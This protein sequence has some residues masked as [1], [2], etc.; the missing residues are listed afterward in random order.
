MINA[1]ANAA[2]LEA[3]LW[4]Q[5]LSGHPQYAGEVHQF[6]VRHAA[7][8]EFNSRNDV[9]AHI[10]TYQ[11]AFRRELS[12]RQTEP[13]AQAHQL[14]AYGVLGFGHSASNQRRQTLLLLAHGHCVVFHTSWIFQI[15]RP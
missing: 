3:S 11:L 15:E 2:L 7:D 8:L 12:L 10:P 5:R 13:I 4:Q 6:N 14:R 9:A 1:G